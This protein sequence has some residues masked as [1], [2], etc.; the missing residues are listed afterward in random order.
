MWSSKDIIK[1]SRKKE[2]LYYK[3]DGKLWFCYSGYPGAKSSALIQ[4]EFYQIAKYVVV[5]K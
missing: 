3:R 1:I 2:Q 4:T 5:T